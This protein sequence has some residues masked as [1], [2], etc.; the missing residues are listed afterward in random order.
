MKKGKADAALQYAMTE[1]RRYPPQMQDLAVY[2][3]TRSFISAAAALMT[4][5][6]L[7]GRGVWS[8]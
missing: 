8:L 2:E 3:S 5:D 7:F 4:R 1:S 6:L